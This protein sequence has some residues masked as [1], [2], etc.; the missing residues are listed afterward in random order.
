MSIAA[1]ITCCVRALFRHTYADA[2]HFIDI[3]ETE[4][5]LDSLLG[6]DDSESF[7]SKA[8][9]ARLLKIML[10]RLKRSLNLTPV[11]YNSWG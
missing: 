3:E 4:A 1:M 7:M 5:F 6:S 11:T 8:G 2:L 9:P 10:K